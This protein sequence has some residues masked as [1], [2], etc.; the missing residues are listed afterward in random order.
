MLEGTE[1]RDGVEAAEAV[2]ADLEGVLEPSVEPVPPARRR[3]RRRE[4][5][6]D[7]GASADPDEVEQG[8][9]AAT[10][11]EHAPAGVDPDLIGDVLVL[12]TLGLLEAEREIAVELGAAEVRQLAQAEPEDAVDERVGELEVVAI[13]HLRG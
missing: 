5:D 1:A 6:A 2:G 3:L 9:P 13:G 11:I 4:R 7:A 8:T 10:Q 12:S